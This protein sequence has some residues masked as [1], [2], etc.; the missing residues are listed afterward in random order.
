MTEI[1]LVGLGGGIGAML[2]YAISSLPVRTLFPVLT[3]AVNL[4]GA[5][6]IGLVTGFLET[7]ADPPVWVSPLLKTG[8][9]GG[10]TTFS[11]FS[12]ETV[13]LWRGGHPGLSALYAVCSVAVCAAGVVLG[14]AVTRRAL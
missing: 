8:L 9:C 14:R 5:F 3:L 13:T 6:I 7:R 10:F 11:T 1:L 12:L 2:R 4:L